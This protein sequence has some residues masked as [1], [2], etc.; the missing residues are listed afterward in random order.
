RPG[1]GGLPP[2]T[3]M[4][5]ARWRNTQAGLVPCECLHVTAAAGLVI[6]AHPLGSWQCRRAG[7]EKLTVLK[8]SCPLESHAPIPSYRRKLDK[9]G[10]HG[11]AAADGGRP[12]RNHGRF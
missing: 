7:T 12:C 10:D 4:N 11:S 6:P 9:R 8:C 2:I 1:A 3:A 5:L